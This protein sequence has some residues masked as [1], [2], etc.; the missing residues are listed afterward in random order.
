MRCNIYAFKLKFQICVAS[1]S[2]RRE[3]L[4]EEEVKMLRKELK[5]ALIEKAAL[6]S[7]LEVALSLSAGLSVQ[8]PPA[9]EDTAS[10]GFNSAQNTPFASPVADKWQASSSAVEEKSGTVLME[11]CRRGDLQVSASVASLK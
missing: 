11:A 3:F 9:A 10:S 5:Q 6:A 2:A 7:Q 8:A 4:L 1:E